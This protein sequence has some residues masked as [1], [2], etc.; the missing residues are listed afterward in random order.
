MCKLPA[1]ASGPGGPGPLPRGNLGL[2]KDV[3][4]SLWVHLQDMPKAGAGERH[5]RPTNPG[6]GLLLPD[7]GL[8]MYLTTAGA[9]P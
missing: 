4:K 6:H 3:E 9:R 8:G 1:A 2:G 5:M 7:R